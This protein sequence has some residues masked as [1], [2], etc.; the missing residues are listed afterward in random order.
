MTQY[1]DV[2]PQTPQVRLLRSAADLLRAGGVIACPTDSTYALMCHLGDKDSLDRIRRIRRLPADH[3]LTLMCRDLSHLSTF[4]RVDNPTYRQLRRL[5]PGS[6]TFL[7]EAARGVP[8]RLLHPKRR[9]IGLRVPAHAI[10]EGLLGALD[11][12]L[13]TTTLRLPDDEVPLSDPHEVR[14]RLAG[15]IDLIIDGGFC[16]IEATTVIDLTAPEPR[17]VRAGLGAWPA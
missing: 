14:S 4:A 10:A 3:N 9:T 11:D 16:G 15:Q 17:L 1:F 12:A 7:L 6:Y 2:H 13:L 8:K 5:T